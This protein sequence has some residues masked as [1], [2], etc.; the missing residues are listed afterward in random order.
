MK[1][2]AMLERGDLDGRAVWLRIVEAINELQRQEPG[3]GER[4]H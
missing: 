2:D 3:A 4:R 1:A